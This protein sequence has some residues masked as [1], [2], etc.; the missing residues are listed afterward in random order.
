[1]KLWILAVGTKMPAWVD[2]AFGEY[3]KRMPRE[4]RVELLEIR[5]EKRV[6]GK[7]AAQMQEAE[8]ARIQSS[9]PDNVTT[10][11]LDERGAEWSTLELAGQMK[12]WLQDGRD[13]AFVIG[14]ADGLHPDL[15]EQAGRLWSL[16]R[17]TLPHGMVRV[18]LAEQL[19]RAMTVIQNHPYHRE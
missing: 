15:R 7:T 19:Y 2:G 5:P 18:L 14:G 1:M 16:S 13:V 9:L 11:M 10:I 3:A 8:M 6:G 4:A 12:N 17:L